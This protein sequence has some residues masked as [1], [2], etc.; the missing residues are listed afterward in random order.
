ML[1][2]LGCR[3]LLNMREA[4][5]R[6]SNEGTMCDMKSTLSGIVFTA[7]NHRVGVHEQDVIA[8]VELE[9]TDFS[10]GVIS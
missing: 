3:L 9:L 6:G 8:K 10:R 1:S 4:L 2:I 5:L 7:P